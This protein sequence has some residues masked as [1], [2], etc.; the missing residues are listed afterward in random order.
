MYSTVHSRIDNYSFITVLEVLSQMLALQI[1]EVTI[2]STNC[3][4]K[5]FYVYLLI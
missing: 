5:L 1:L 4:Q 3:R 2:L